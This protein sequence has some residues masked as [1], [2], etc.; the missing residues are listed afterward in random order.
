MGLHAA[1]TASPYLWP[2]AHDV[3]PA[4]QA[5]GAGGCTD[6]HAA[7]SAFLFGLVPT[8][9]APTGDA[10][11]RVDAAAFQ[12]L[13]PKMGSL[14]METTYWPLEMVAFQGLDRDFQSAFALTFVFRPWLKATGFAACGMMAA[15]LAA[16][17]LLG[18]VGMCRRIGGLT[19]RRR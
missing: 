6:C 13:D 11:A 7:G 12:R 10:G 8:R 2:L 1:Q 4:A 16:F 18:V 3:R 9:S 19:S 14:Y 17:G 15:V 5:L